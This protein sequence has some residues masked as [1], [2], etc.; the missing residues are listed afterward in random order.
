MWLTKGPTPRSTPGPS[1][2]VAICKRY[3]VESLLLLGTGHFVAWFIGRVLRA[4]E[5]KVH[6]PNTYLTVTKE[7]RRSAVIL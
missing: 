3:L 2:S 6:G 7:S 1:R 5:N 4:D